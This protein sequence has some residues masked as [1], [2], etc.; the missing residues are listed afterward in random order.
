MVV[1][2]KFSVYI[3]HAHM[4][5]I[6][7]G[8]TYRA[9]ICG[10]QPCMHGYCQERMLDISNMYAYM[11]DHVYIMCTHLPSMQCCLDSW[12]TSDALL[13]DVALYD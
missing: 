7:V 1:C 3:T 13:S 10:G 8:D 9:C 2:F 5:V 11:C 6:S 12:H 4:V